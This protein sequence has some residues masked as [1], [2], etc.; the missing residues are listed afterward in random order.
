MSELLERIKLIKH[1]LNELETPYK[2]MTPWEVNFYESVRA[3]FEERNWLSD[4]QF[5]ILERIYTEKT[6]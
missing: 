3:Q 5:E 2:N 6:A 1:M 4:R